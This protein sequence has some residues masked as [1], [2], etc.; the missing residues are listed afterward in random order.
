MSAKR[1]AF[2]V[3]ILGDRGGEGFEESTL[4]A[5]VALA[6]SASPDYRQLLTPRGVAAFF[7]ASSAAAQRANRLVAAAEQLRAGGSGFEGLGIG[8]SSGEMI[9]DFSWLGRVR[10]TPLGAV[11]N[12]ASRLVSSAPDAYL[13]SLISIRDAYRYA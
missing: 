3:V 1:K 12:D 4:L 11:A 13:P 10:S 2:I 6:D 5:L 7:V 9:A 8:I